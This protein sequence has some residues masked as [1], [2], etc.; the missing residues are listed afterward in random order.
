M[1]KSDFE[2]LGRSFSWFF[3]RI[4]RILELL[5]ILFST[6]SIGKYTELLKQTSSPHLFSQTCSSL[7]KF[8]FLVLLW[9]KMTINHKRLLLWVGLQAFTAHCCVI[10]NSNSAFQTWKWSVHRNYYYL[11]WSAPNS[12]A[13]L[14]SAKWIN[15]NWL[16][17]KLFGHP[18]YPEITYWKSN[19]YSWRMWEHCIYIPLLS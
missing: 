11:L 1:K 15:I 14:V 18:D 10:R 16:E 4:C 13:N 7:E 9:N 5:H 17:K 3:V 6:C 12:I 19:F 2:G 8:F